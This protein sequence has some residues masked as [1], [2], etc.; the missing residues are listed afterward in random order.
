MYRGFCIEECEMDQKKRLGD[1]AVDTGRHIRMDDD[2]TGTSVKK[3]YF[4]VLLCHVG[5]QQENRKEYEQTTIINFAGRCNTRL[6]A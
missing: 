6:S 1:G 5:D 4:S 2:G 3:M